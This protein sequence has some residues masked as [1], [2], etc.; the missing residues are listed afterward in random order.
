MRNC[1]QSTKEAV[2][3]TEF[4]LDGMQTSYV[5]IPTDSKSS[6]LGTNLSWLRDPTGEGRAPGKMR[7]GLCAVYFSNWYHSL[8]LHLGY[9]F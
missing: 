9:I 7:Q 5:L 1:M 3:N 4:M 2:R 8:E 6:F